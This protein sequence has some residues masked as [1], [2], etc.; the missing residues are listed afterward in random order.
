MKSKIILSLVMAA[1]VTLGATAM[2]T[3]AN[4]NATAVSSGNVMTMGTVQLQRGGEQ[5]GQAIQMDK[6]FSG[7]NMGFNKEVTT[8]AAINIRG[9]LP[10]ALSANVLGVKLPSNE[11]YTSAGFVGNI[12]NH[13]LTINPDARW[14]RQYKMAIKVVVTRDG[15]PILQRVSRETPDGYDSFF[16]TI[17]GTTHNG[18][19]N[20]KGISELLGSLGTLKNGDVVTI[21]TKMKLI[22]DLYDGHGVL[23]STHPSLSNDEQNIFQGESIGADIKLIATEVQ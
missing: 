6:L 11:A 16:D 13:F 9:S 20:T 3:N 8:T 19:P 1:T 7:S 2:S 10:V 15:S 12:T 22:S 5:A 17:N 23:I 18:A 4:F 21:T 14:W